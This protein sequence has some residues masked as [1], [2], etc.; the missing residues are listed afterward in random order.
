M[1]PVFAA[2][3]PTFSSFSAMVNLRFYLTRMGTVNF[4]E[5]M[6]TLQKGRNSPT[7]LSSESGNIID[8]PPETCIY[9]AVKEQ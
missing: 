2:D 9:L 4:K 3:Q 7:A 1:F 5:T 6:L 8:L